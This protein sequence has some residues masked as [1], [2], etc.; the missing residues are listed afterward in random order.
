MNIRN[1]RYAKSSIVATPEDSRGIMKGREARLLDAL[2]GRYS[3][4]EGGYILPASKRQ[5]LEAMTTHRWDAKRRLLPGSP[6]VF[7]AP[8]GSQHSPNEAKK[9]LLKPNP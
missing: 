1:A 3:H 8:G 5:F 6:S 2:N 9:I 7:V 4:R